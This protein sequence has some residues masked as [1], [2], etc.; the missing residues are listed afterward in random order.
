MSLKPGVLG[1]GALHVEVHPQDTNHR[2]DVHGDARDAKV[3]TPPQKDDPA[4][5]VLSGARARPCAEI[6]SMSSTGFLISTGFTQT[7][8]HQIFSRN[9]PG[10]LSPCQGE[11][12]LAVA[13]IDACHQCFCRNLQL[14]RF[15]VDVD[16]VMITAGSVLKACPHK[17][18]SAAAICS[19]FKGNSMLSRQPH[20]ESFP[21]ATWL[22]MCWQLLG[23]AEVSS[24][25]VLGCQF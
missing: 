7:Q 3:P 12:A 20:A 15:D 10:S 5:A 9:M 18:S 6:S 19:F 21:C 2:T 4:T 11:S 22:Q 14:Y 1:C 17:H 23:L 24:A 8:L 16:A 13:W 25:S